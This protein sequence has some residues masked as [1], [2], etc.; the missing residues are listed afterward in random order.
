MNAAFARIADERGHLDVLVNAVGVNT[1]T[2]AAGEALNAENYKG[3]TA[4]KEG[5][6]HNPD[7]LGSISDEDFDR[8]MK[9]NLY[10][11]FYT[12]RAAVP[13]LKKAGGGAIVNFSSS[14]ALMAVA[15]PAYYPASMAGLLGLT[16]EVAT[17]LAPFNIRVNALAPDAVVT[18]TDTKG[19]AVTVAR[20][21]ARLEQKQATRAALI[22]RAREL[23]I[24]HGY[25]DTTA[26]TIAKAVGVS[27]ATFYLHFRSKDE[28]VLEHMRA[29]EDSVV[30]AYR[31]LDRT[32]EPNLE[33]V[34]AWLLEHVA[35]WRVHRA[36]FAVM[37][38]ALANEQAVS[39]EWFVMLRRVAARMT[40]LLARQPDDSSRELARMRVMSMLMSTDRN[41]HFAIVQGHE[42]NLDVLVRVLAERWLYCLRG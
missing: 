6:Q 4:A 17:E 9:I 18:S 8:V 41:L 40:N 36:E 10:G 25:T 13:L 31:A 2:R 7:F 42:E 21:M 37:E 39:D 5:Q 24:E 1:P 28:I 22:D 16:R 23:F 15:M 27:R 19:G 3:F 12:I 20:S 29:R 35:F 32:D 33:S 26:D 11:P 14:T 30:E 38:Q 34:T